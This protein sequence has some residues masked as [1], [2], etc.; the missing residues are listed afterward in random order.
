MINNFVVRLECDYGRKPVQKKVSNPF[1]HRIAKSKRTNCP[2]H[3]N[4]RSPKHLGVCW[5]ITTIIDS[6]NHDI[7]MESAG[8]RQEDHIT[9]EI[10]AKIKQYSKADLGINKTLIL[11]RDD[12]PNHQLETR[13]VGNAIAKAKQGDNSGISQ[14]AQLLILLQ[15]CQKEDPRWFVRKDV[16][17]QTG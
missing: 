3:I 10:F 4:I 17:E 6:H 16:D 1:Q 14:A 13:Q 11:L 5:H 7:E 12:F 15:G 8:L 2:F 9:P